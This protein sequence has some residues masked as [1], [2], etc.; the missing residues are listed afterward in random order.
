MG[1][2]WYWTRRILPPVFLGLVLYI[3]LYL[4]QVVRLTPSLS[5]Y[6]NSAIGINIEKQG[7]STGFYTISGQ[8]PWGKFTS[9]VQIGINNRLLTETATDPSGTFSVETKL[10]AQTYVVWVKVQDPASGEMISNS[11]NFQVDQAIPPLVRVAYYV[12]EGGFLW[13]AGQA[14]GGGVQ[15]LD[16]NG[17]TVGSTNATVTGDFDVLIPTSAG[18]PEQVSVEATSNDNGRHTVRSDP[19]PI[20]EISLEELPLQRKMLVQMSRDQTRIDLDITLPVEHPYFQSLVEGYID[21]IQFTYLSAGIDPFLLEQLEITPTMQ[22]S[23]PVGG[24]GVGMVHLKG[25]W[26]EPLNGF[27]ITSSYVSPDNPSPV[28]LS[29]LPL[30]TRRDQVELRFEGI[31]PNWISQP[32]PQVL[33][34]QRA[35]WIG[36]LQADS[37]PIIDVKLDRSQAGIAGSAVNQADESAQQ[38][39]AQQRREFYASIGN[40]RQRGF[41]SQTVSG[42]IRL[43]PYLA[44]F[45][46]A[47]RGFGRR[48]AWK[49]LLAIMV[50]F[51]VWRN[52]SWFYN[53]TVSQLAPWLYNR[54]SEFRYALSLFG[55]GGA[56]RSLFNISPGTFWLMFTAL[57]CI[58]PMLLPVLEKRPARNKISRE[59]GPKRRAIWRRLWLVGRILWTLVLGGLFIVVRLLWDQ[60]RNGNFQGIN[61][62]PALFDVYRLSAFLTPWSYFQGGDPTQYIRDLLV[63]PASLFLIQLILLTLILLA[64]WGRAALF[65]LGLLGVALRAAAEPFIQGDAAGWLYKPLMDLVNLVDNSASLPGWMVNMLP[66]EGITWWLVMILA[67]LSALP[68]ISSLLKGLAPE[69][70]RQKKPHLAGWTAVILGFMAFLLPRLPVQAVLWA[71]GVLAIGVAGWLALHGLWKIKPATD[72]A[73]HFKV[74]KLRYNLPLVLLMLLIASG[75]VWPMASPGKALQLADFGSLIGLIGS[76][77]TFVLAL[78]LALML[79]EEAVRRRPGILLDQPVLEAG[80]VLFSAFVINSLLIWLYIPVPFLVG[81]VI[82]WWFLFRPV[83]PQSARQSLDEAIVK[84]GQNREV[85]V[86]D[87]LDQVTASASFKA[88]QKSMDKDFEASKLTP[89]TYEATL[90]SYREYYGDKLEFIQVAPGF[91]SRQ[92]VF[93]FLE[94]DRWDSTIRMMKVG[95][96]LALV[97]LVVAIYGFMGQQGAVYPYPVIT[98]AVFLISAVASWLLYAFFF[99]YFY[100]HL[101]GENGLEKGMVM[102]AGLVLPFLVYRVINAQT[103]SEMN[104]FIQWALQIFLFCSLL[105]ILVGEYRLIRRRG[106]PLRDLLALHN[107]PVL[108][109]YLSG[110]V[111]ALVPAVIAVITGRL[112]EWVTFFIN[113]VI[114]HAPNIGQ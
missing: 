40:L 18:P 47:S 8:V 42:L 39:I 96:W 99:G 61:G 2:V 104:S 33:D 65:S 102:F 85:Y 13:V 35:V 22:I 82:A 44:L 29:D 48:A 100:D 111:A 81:L 78:A 67:T 84:T 43:I 51:A 19:F 63:S 11:M 54:V 112:G 108:S 16:Q 89:E 9:S 28:H 26:K 98:L 46:L 76:L 107:L 91:N 5:D 1:A 34:G 79:Y 27:L 25:G 50:V 68:L 88:I 75:L 92:V 101:R 56:Y 58:T 21:P 6:P 36:P 97:P 10:P 93:S 14:E 31:R 23:H 70:L 80:V 38:A 83:Q 87:A 57:I 45:W 64:W 24:G 52:W 74:R 7:W 66:S 53:L 114:P 49:P 32:L 69:E 109:V 12:P 95:A 103:I 72:L 37:Q 41:L 113:Y 3:V 30:L 59:S 86:D 71:A 90:K 60:F 62:F 94:T 77:F 17:R 20:S 15:I 4:L 110:V 73:K 55:K 106:Q 105:G